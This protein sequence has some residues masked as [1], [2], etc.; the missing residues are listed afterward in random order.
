MK[1]FLV[2][3]MVLMSLS[4]F[5]G[6]EKPNWFRDTS[7]F[8]R[9]NTLHVYGMGEAKTGEKAA[10][11]AVG[12][13]ADELIKQ[14]GAI[15][16]AIYDRT[17]SAGKKNGKYYHYQRATVSHDDCK[18]TLGM[19]PKY[20]KQMVK[21]N[22][23]IAYLKYKL[24]MESQVTNYKKCSNRNRY[25]YDY[26]VSEY[27]KQNYLTAILYASYSCEKGVHSGCSL[28]WE[29]HGQILRGN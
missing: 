9:G 24:H 6:P 26:V 20:R 13:I 11:V 27:K 19:P 21:K 15:Q 5:A 28:A 3:L 7:S 17:Y 12:R 22:D 2:S 4:V 8:R 16:P 29:I 10:I 18:K 1:A 23:R 14:C 25:C